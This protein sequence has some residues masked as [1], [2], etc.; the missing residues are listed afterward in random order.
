[1][2]IP[3]ELL[4]FWEL[5]KIHFE[6]S[7]SPFI[8]EWYIQ[9][10]LLLLALIATLT[11]QIWRWT[12]YFI[13][14]FHE[15]GH[16]LAALTV[17]SKL[18]G[19]TIRWDRSGE[20]MSAGSSFPLFRVWTLWWGYPFPTALGSVYIWSAL[21]GW[22]GVAMTLTLI[23][24]AVMFIQVRS[25]MA[26]F[27]IGLTLLGTWFVWWNLPKEYLS[28][29]LYGIGCFLIIGGVKVLESLTRQHFKGDTENSDA[30][31]LQETLL[32]I[33][34]TFWLASFWIGTFVSIAFVLKTFYGVS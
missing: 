26:L 7:K 22:S 24:I 3:P 18:R 21:K 4:K 11:P 28:V 20:T 29:I 16:A 9:L 13:T 5:V 15:G 34:A 12:G 30:K 10:F 27:S 6:N 17:G 14:V 8:E 2:N 31:H 25:V 33:P 32:I 19:I 1:M 23:M